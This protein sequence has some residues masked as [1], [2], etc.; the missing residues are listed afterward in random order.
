MREALST[1]RPSRL[2]L[3]GFLTLAAGGAMLGIGATRTWGSVGLSAEIDPTRAITAAIPGVDVWEGKL[4]LAAAV[5]VLIGMLALRLTRNPATRQ[6]I[7]VTI[8]IVGFGAAALALTAALDAP[9]RF[10]QTEGLDAYARV[11][12]EELALPFDQVRADIEDVFLED[13]LVETDAGIWLVVAGGT[14]AGIG[15]ILSIAW[16]RRQRAD[17]RPAA[18]DPAGTPT[19]A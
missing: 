3:A 16:A 6:S 17:A 1:A 15:G 12:S 14:L 19:S 9:D 11:L 7:A 5:V 8:T 4:A 10:V 18:P 13:L 2:R